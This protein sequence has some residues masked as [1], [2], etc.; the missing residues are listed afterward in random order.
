MANL[1]DRLNRELDS[2]GKKAQ[3]ALDEGKLQLELMRAR[4][5][6][7]NAAVDLG[8]LVHRRERGREVDG[9][10]IDALLGRLDEI[11]ETIARLEREL[12]AQ[13]GDTVSVSDQPPPASAQTGEAEV[14]DP[15]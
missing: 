5:Q 9:R 6:E 4:R 13:R 14:V 2:L 11:Q 1:I 3:A 12:A 15:E 8:L 10:R 7:K